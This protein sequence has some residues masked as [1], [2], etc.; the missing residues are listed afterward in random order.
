MQLTRQIFDT[1]IGKIL[2][3]WITLGFGAALLALATE[4]IQIVRDTSL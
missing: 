3:P 2:M 1:A 4:V